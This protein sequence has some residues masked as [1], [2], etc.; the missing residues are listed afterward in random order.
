MKDKSIFTKI[1][2]REIPADIIFENDKVIAFRDISPRALVH[3]LVVPKE[4]VESMLEASPETLVAVLE[5]CKEVARRE[6]I[7]ETGFR[8]IFNTGEGG[9]Q[10]VFH[11]HAHVI[12]GQQLVWNPA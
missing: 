7:T 5:G 12:G 3:V 1:I 10:T 6:G 9:G 8:I 4:P 11:L 2:E